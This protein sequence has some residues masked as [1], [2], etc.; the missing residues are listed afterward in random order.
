MKWLRGAV[1]YLYLTV[2]VTDEKDGREM[3][4]TR[5]GARTAQRVLYSFLLPVMGVRLL[6]KCYTG[7]FLVPYF[8]LIFANAKI[9]DKSE[10]QQGFNK[11]EKKKHRV[12]QYCLET[13]HFELLRSTFDSTSLL[14]L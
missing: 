9:K 5:L 4:H 13:V 3:K 10:L 1:K 6:D 8:I 2:C 7:R 14:F 11:Q 12:D